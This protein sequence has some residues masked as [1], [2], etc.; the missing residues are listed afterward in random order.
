MLFMVLGPFYFIP[1][2]KTGSKLKDI[3]GGFLFGLFY[4]VFDLTVGTAI[5]LLQ[6]AAQTLRARGVEAE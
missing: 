5:R 4:T 2:K 6:S 1:R 3:A